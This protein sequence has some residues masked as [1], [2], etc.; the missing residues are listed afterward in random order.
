MEGCASLSRETRKD[1]MGPQMSSGG[2]RGVPAW[3]PR[4]S[5]ASSVEVKCGGD[6]LSLGHA[7][8]LF[9]PHFP[10]L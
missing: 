9:E 6:G 5:M 1:T 2:A 7:T 8:Y 3:C 10:H 4:H